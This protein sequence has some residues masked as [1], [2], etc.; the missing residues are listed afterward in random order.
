MNR[1]SQSENPLTELLAERIQ[2][3]GGAMS[4]E[5]FMGVCLYEPQ[6]G[7]YMS[8]RPKLGKQ[9]DYYTSAFVGTLMGQ[10]AAGRMAE[11]ARQIAAETETVTVIEWGGGDG[12][13][14]SSILNE[15]QAAHPELYRRL[16]W[17]GAESS[18]YHRALQ[19]ERL[20]S[21]MACVADIVP[22]E[23]EL[24]DAA[25][26][27]DPCLLVANELLD[28]FPVHRLRYAGG[29][30]KEIYVA[31]KTEHSRL[32]E[33][34][35]P[36]S[37]RRLFPLIGDVPGAEGQIIEVGRQGLN[38]IRDI[39]R[40]MNRGFAL[41]IDYGDVSSELL[42]PHRMN[43]TLVTYKRHQAGDDPYADPGQQDITAHVNFEWC[44]E[45]AKEA[46]FRDIRLYT[47]K[48]LLVEQGIL[49]RLQEHDGRDPFSEEARSNRAIRQLLLSDGM[50][51]LF[52]VL[53]MFK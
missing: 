20:A 32:E 31:W 12:R 23:S 10:C 33:I 7:Y 52:K 14:A 26:R 3:S 35:G 29:E 8:E 25:L 28:A 2:R 6:Y 50:S 40:R 46:D 53:E 17:V 42:A 45:A 39:G 47:Q 21:H 43:G 51:E 24:L 34:D 30:W 36:L 41:L 44:M 49:G 27:R 11:A 38:W 5:E 1:Q 9:G 22:P 13:L 15:L 48:Q 4:F 16:R 18:P 19:W 37:H